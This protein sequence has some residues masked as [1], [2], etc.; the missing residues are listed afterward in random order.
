MAEAPTQSEAHPGVAAASTHQQPGIAA[1]LPAASQHV[2]VGSAGAK[3]QTPARGLRQAAEDVGQSAAGGCCAQAAQPPAS[4]AG[5]EAAHAE[6]DTAAPL[7]RRSSRIAARHGRR[8]AQTDAGMDSGDT[9]GPSHHTAA[10]APG[11]APHSSA[12][13]PSPPQQPLADMYGAAAL[14]LAFAMSALLFMA[15]LLPVIAPRASAHASKVHSHHGHDR[16][17]LRRSSCQHCLS[18]WLTHKAW[19]IKP[20]SCR[21]RC[22]TKR[23]RLLTACFDT[24]VLFA[25]VL[26]AMTMAV[27]VAPL[28]KQPAARLNPMFTAPDWEASF[29][30]HDSSASPR[31]LC[32]PLRRQLLPCRLTWGTHAVPRQ[33]VTVVGGAL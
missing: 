19:H 11:A 5:Q 17:A 3:A 23:K 14:R 30:F 8:D 9:P 21:H 16:S 31:G 28:L 12:E 24:Q 33:Y 2:H 6:D 29:L 32:A 22:I 15:L 18:S 20:T 13:P 10:G 26:G 4:A 1:P 25:A 27:A 7:R